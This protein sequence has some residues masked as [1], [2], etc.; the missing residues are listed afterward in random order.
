MAQEFSREEYYGR[1]K[2]L[3]VSRVILLTFLLGTLLFF[4]YGYRIYSF[5]TVHLGYILLS[6]YALTC[7]YWYLLKKSRNLSFLAYLQVSG[8]ILLITLLVYITGGIDSG[9]SLLYHL[10]IISASIILY[11]RGGYLSASLSSILYG[12]LL[13]MQ[14][15]DALGLVRSPNFTAMQ[16]LYQ[17]FINIL[18]FYTVAFLSGYLSDRLRKTSQELRAKS[19]D[20][21]DLRTM[22]DHI[23]KSVRSG[24][25][26]TDLEGQMT[27]CNPAAESITGFS[28][29]ELK[30]IWHDIFGDSIKGLFGHTDDLKERPYRFDG[31][32]VKKNGDMAILGISASLLR[33]DKNDIRGIILVFQDITKLVEMEEK[34]R[35]QEQ[36]AMVGSL[37]AGIA[38]EIRNPLASLSGSIQVLQ[39]ELHLEGDD[40]HLMDIVVR[41][42][43][44]LNTIITEFLDYARPQTIQAERI[45][46]SSILDET[47]LLLKN[48]R[49][50]R[51]GITIRV[52]AD[53]HVAIR[54]DAQRMR[55]VFWNLLINSC[56]AIPDRGEI[57]V[58]TL[59]LSY[60]G[61]D[62]AWCEI[63]IQDTGCGISPEYLDKIFDP[64]F[65]TKTSGTGLGLAIVNRIIEDHGGVI[66]VESG[67][68]RGTKFR[69][70]LPVLEEAVSSVARND[71]IMTQDS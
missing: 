34:I 65:T 69:I 54:G 15:Y 3:M 71:H 55:Q 20:Y 21:E 2:W 67:T 18:S 37:A 26:T 9:F 49:D 6:I 63:I 52:D 45:I 51:E 38:H 44:R 29:M 7:I 47:I 24:I 64:F 48:S 40:K 59:P 33:D 19:M 14:Y 68:G 8:D 36:L 32:I 25:L 12:C 58:S 31:R 23:L 53:P 10:T 13:D 60:G 30:S 41:E 11:R 22:Q 27:S 57:T 5:P 4:Q 39:G 17:V 62:A 61:G 70:R 66:D 56:Q 42:T 28:Y 50:F 43:D 1:L 16:V 46:V 35:R